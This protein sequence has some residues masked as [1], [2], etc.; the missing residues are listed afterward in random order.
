MPRFQWVPPSAL[1]Q[2]RR[3]AST[4]IV[5]GPAAISCTPESRPRVSA[6]TATSCHVDPPSGVRQ[7]AGSHDVGEAHRGVNAH[8]LRSS[9]NATWFTT[10]LHRAALGAG[11]GARGVGS[12]L[13]S[14]PKVATPAVTATAPATSAA[15]NP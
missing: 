5:W 12:G 8:P 11:S 4:V 2:R 14:G 9:A 3:P 7:N 10:V 1:S 15:I 13:G 6:G